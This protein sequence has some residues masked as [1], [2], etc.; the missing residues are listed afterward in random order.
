MHAGTFLMVN[1]VMNYLP[2]PVLCL[3]L[4]LLAAVPL[5]AVAG[6][7]PA[8]PA[9][10]GTTAPL[11]DAV[12]PSPAPRFDV[13]EYVVEGNSVLTTPAIEEAVYSHMGEQKT[14]QDVEA[15][16]AALE[17]AYHDA[18]YL[19]VFV[20]LP[21]QQVKRG[22]VRL[23][24]A[25]GRV[26]RLRVSGSHYYALGQI[27][28]A[29]PELA[30]G[31]VPY[32]PEMQKELA[33]L[34]RSADRK[35]T[36]VLR[37]GRTPGTLEAELKVEDR[38]PLHG[39][40]ELDDRYSANTTRTRLSGGLRYDNLFQRQHSLSLG[41]QIAPEQLDDSK[42]FSATYVMPMPGGNFL[43]G[44]AIVNKSDV[45]VTGDLNTVGNGT[46]LGLRYIL[47]LRT[48]PGYFHSLTLGT[49]Y[50]DFGET[51]TLLGADSLN[52]PVSYLPFTL[53]YDATLRDARRVTQM[54]L[55]F[56]FSIRGLGNDDQEFE[57]KRTGAKADYAYLRADL[58]HDEALPAGWSLRGRLAGQLASGPLISNEEFAAGGADSVR[59][60]LESAALG[61]DGLNAGLELRAP[62]L[63]TRVSAR[64]TDFTPF[65][66]VEG[67]RLRVLQAQPG[68]ISRFDLLGA[69]LGLRFAG[70]GGVSG[71]LAW[72]YPFN[73][74]GPVRAGEDRVHF[75][76]GYEW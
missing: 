8:N 70:W 6:T 75:R 26:E 45:A 43:A 52:R 1:I 76:L 71:D 37:P 63:A 55:S 57:L 72:A 59:G 65:A 3:L 13:L 30:E 74:V 27:K 17:K 64:M 58:K 24:V 53:G 9:P 61:D 31:E 28:A 25:E 40:L 12:P 23:K 41:F 18:G 7:A 44:Y 42:V 33:G 21:E 2:R 69:G 51:I 62:S 14:L 10:G 29:T 34:N 38:L 66:F 5:G 4:G 73:E 60:Y 47:P 50:K 67:A 56:N 35:V 20:D 49:D 22:V 68:Q 15:A 16:R 36:P 39:N 11:P 54:K 46:V 48:L 32:F 19:T